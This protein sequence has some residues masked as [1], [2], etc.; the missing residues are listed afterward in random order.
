MSPLFTVGKVRVLPGAKSVYMDGI[1]SWFV[2]TFRTMYATNLILLMLMCP[3]VW[4]DAIY[5][6]VRKQ[7]HYQS[8]AVYNRS[9]LKPDRPQ[10]GPG[11]VSR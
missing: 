11:A 2:N 3:F 7:G 1:S 8:R 10:G 9:G 6:K 5:Y 4:L